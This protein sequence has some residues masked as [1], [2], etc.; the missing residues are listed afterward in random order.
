LLIRKYTSGP[1]VSPWPAPGADGR[2]ATPQ[3]EIPF[4]IDEALALMDEAGINRPVIVPSS[5]EGDCTDPAL[6]AAHR[7]PERFAVMGGIAPERPEAP[8]QIAGWRK[9]PGMLGLPCG[10]CSMPM[11]TPSARNASSGAPTFNA[12]T[13]LAL[14][15]RS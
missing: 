8:A 7:H 4:G 13:L 12:R 11:M 14:C 1:P 2:S 15:H 3:R 5:W 10:S 9:Q 6:A